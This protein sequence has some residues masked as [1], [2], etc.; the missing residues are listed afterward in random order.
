[1]IFVA[2]IADDR[3]YDHY[4]PIMGE[5]TIRQ[6][7]NGHRHGSVSN[8]LFLDAHVRAYRLE[9]TLAP[10]NLHLTPEIRQMLSGA[11]P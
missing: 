7:L 1:L 2:E 11:P 10:V 5:R 8:Y 4:H 3:S 9:E 6:E